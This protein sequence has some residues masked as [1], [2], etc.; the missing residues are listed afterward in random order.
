V[1]RDRTSV[2]DAAASALLVAFGSALA[3]TALFFVIEW[4]V[5]IA[6]LARPLL[7]IA[8][9]ALLAAASFAAAP[10]RWRRPCALVALLLV[11]GVY[12]GE[13]ALSYANWLKWSAVLADSD[14]RPKV[15][16]VEELRSAGRDAWPIAPPASLS[17][18]VDQKAPPFDRARLLPLGGIS[19]VP[20]VFCGEGRPFVVYQSDRYG[21]FNPESAFDAKPNVMLLGDSYVHGYCVGPEDGIVPRLREQFPGALNFGMSGDG[22]L[23]MLATL[24]EYGPAIEPEFV[25]W[26]FF[27]GNDFDDL[28]RERER[29]VLTAYLDPDNRQGLS[30]RQAEVDSLLRVYIEGEAVNAP[31]T[32]IA[33][34]GGMRASLGRKLLPVVSLHNLLP[35]LGLPTGRID[36]EYGLLEEILASAQA[37]VS[38]WSGQLI[39]AYLPL[40]AE[41]SGLSRFDADTSY[42]RQRTLAIVRHLGI[43]IVDLVPAIAALPDPTAASC[44]PRT[45]YN[46]L[47]YDLVA[48]EI[49]AAVRSLAPGAR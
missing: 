49:A 24:R 6:G 30:E 39:F 2:I 43:P 25:V 4:H 19:K 8:L 21:F 40:T 10:S 42:S 45:H 36:F 13:L 9:P 1:S 18:A 15:E 44:T 33:E 20:S 11:G 23:L 14:P 29:S 7:F 35:Y 17:R 12:G 27:S 48:R 38:S 3:A 34:V 32:P 26:S 28:E 37:E 5:Y 46:E 41:L 22:P 16:V 31:R 47:G